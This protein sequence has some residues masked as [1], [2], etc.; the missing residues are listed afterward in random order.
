MTRRYLLDVNSWAWERVR[1]DGANIIDARF[2][3]VSNGLFLD[4]TGLTGNDPNDADVIECKNEHR[5]STSDIFPLRDSIFEGVSA[6]IPYAYTQILADEYSIESLSQTE[7]RNHTFNSQQG[8]WQKVLMP[9]S[10]TQEEP[11][12]ADGAFS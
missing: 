8:F 11:A 3:D 12:P 2:I 5:Y 6:K 4:I 10:L 9:E 7:F 1:G